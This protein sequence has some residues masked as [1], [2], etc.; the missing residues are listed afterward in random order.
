MSARKLVCGKTGKNRQESM[1][2]LTSVSVENFDFKLLPL[3]LAFNFS[4]T[5][6]CSGPFFLAYL[7]IA[8]RG[9]PP[10]CP[11]K[12]CKKQILYRVVSAYLVHKLLNTV[13][14]VVLPRLVH[15]SQFGSIHVISD[16]VERGFLQQTY[17]DK[18]QRSCCKFGLR[19]LSFQLMNSAESCPELSSAVS[20]LSSPMISVKAGYPVRSH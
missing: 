6:S 4:I 5:L 19:L 9:N 7:S 2:S 11:C 15:H 18:G 12:S 3:Y 8:L 17:R 13:S 10:K 20:L 14:E 1:G 16:I